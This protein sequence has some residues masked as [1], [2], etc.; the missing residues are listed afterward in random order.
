MKKISKYKPVRR[1]V[2]CSLLLVFVSGFVLA[3]GSA[4]VSSQSEPPVPGWVRCPDGNWAPTSVECSAGGGSP[5]PVRPPNI[6]AE[7]WNQDPT[8]G[9]T[10]RSGTGT[11]YCPGGQVPVPPGADPA[12]YC[13]RVGFDVPMEEMPLDCMA[14]DLNASTCAIIGRLNTFIYALSSLVAVVVVAMIALGGIQYSASRDNP[15]EAQAAKTRIRNALLALIVYIFG[16][17]I[18]Q[19][20]IPGGIL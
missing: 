1:A 19:W 5:Q 12:V 8:G 18:L 16:L 4:P 20:L 17:A 14:E 13:R 9:S 11:S 6:P 7:D 3:F 15:Q 10:P 2:F